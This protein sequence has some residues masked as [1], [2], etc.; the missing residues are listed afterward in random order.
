MRLGSHGIQYFLTNQ[1]HSFSL[2]RPWFRLTAISHPPSTYDYHSL[3]TPANMWTPKLPAFLLFSVF[4]L[5]Q[6]C[7]TP[8][9]ATVDI[10]MSATQWLPRVSPEIAQIIQE[11]KLKYARYADTHQWA[12]F[13]EVAF[14]DCTYNY[15][16]HGVVIVDHGNTYAWNST[17]GFTDFFSNAF[18][19]LQT[20]HHIGPG[21]FN[22]TDYSLSEVEAIFPIVYHSAIAVGHNSTNGV[23][24]TGGGHYTETYRRKGLDWLMT[25]CSFN[26]IYYQPS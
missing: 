18:S 11:K 16:D 17:K 8:I 9:E 13:K 3:F 2:S 10:D 19:T 24:G 20:M 7:A 5:Q 23:T 14:D 6:V 22:Y 26:Q 12:K 1:L 15:M 21:E 4:H 25:T